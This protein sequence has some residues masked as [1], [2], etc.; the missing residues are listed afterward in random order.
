MPDR[1]SARTRPRLRLC[2]SVARR[3]PPQSRRRRRLRLLQRR[4]RTPARRA[5]GARSARSVL[6][7]VRLAGLVLGPDNLERFIELDVDLAAAVEGHLDLVHA[8]LV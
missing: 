7:V 6:A 8:L 5:R 3:R 1:W 4:L 2:C